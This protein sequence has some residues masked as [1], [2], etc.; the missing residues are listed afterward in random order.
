M[1]MTHTGGRKGCR[2]RWSASG[3]CLE[4][5][6]IHQRQQAPSTTAIGRDDV[7]AAIWNRAFKESDYN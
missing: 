4:D 5:G 6:L 2:E 7:M 1:Y 3:A